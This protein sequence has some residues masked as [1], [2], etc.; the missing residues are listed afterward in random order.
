MK[1]RYHTTNPLVNDEDIKDHDGVG[2]IIHG[3]KDSILIFWH[4]KYQFYTI[5]IGKV[6]DGILP[7]FG[8]KHEVYEEAG[9]VI[10]TLEELGQ[11]RKTY[12]RGAGVHTNVVSHLYDVNGYAGT[13]E[14][15]EPLKHPL[16]IWMTIDQLNKTTCD[17]SDMTR[18]YISLLDI[19]N[20]DSKKLLNEN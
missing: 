3:P 10:Q 8:I 7:V 5:P 13:V 20:T 16:M 19:L 4:E 15:K 2:A 11:F 9:I 12:D 17:L 1:N 18:F 6:P 14:N